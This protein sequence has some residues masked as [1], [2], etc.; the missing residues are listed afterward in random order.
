MTPTQCRAARAALRW[1]ISDLA[2]MAGVHANSISRF[3]NGVGAS[4]DAT[5]ARMRETMEEAGVE[6]TGA[7]GFRME[8]DHEVP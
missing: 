4:R 1:S 5:V 8:S 3:E 2:A 7:T 6:F